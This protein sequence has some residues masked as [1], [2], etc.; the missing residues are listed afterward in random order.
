MQNLGSIIILL[1]LAL[2]LLSNPNIQSNPALK[3]QATAFAGQAI[4][5]AGQ[6][7]TQPAT[8]TL[9]IAPSSSIDITLPPSTPN[10]VVTVTPPQQNQT[11][12]GGTGGPNLGDVTTTPIIRQQVNLTD[13]LDE[14]FFSGNYHQLVLQARIKNGETASTIITLNGL[15]PNDPIPSHKFY[16]LNLDPNLQYDYSIDILGSDWEA[17]T[18]GEL[19]EFLS[20]S[21]YGSISGNTN[22]SQEIINGAPMNAGDFFIVKDGNLVL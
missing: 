7:L 9:G 21:Q 6:A 2:A 5:L 4:A 17:S 16:Y 1:Q 11:N 15:P 10:I 19:P 8:T 12:G 13:K 14:L 3:D 18:T 20:N 22:S